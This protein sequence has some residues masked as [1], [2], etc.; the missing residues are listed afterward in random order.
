MMTKV[1]LVAWQHFRQEVLKRSFIMVMLSLPLFLSLSVG[2]GIWGERLSRGDTTLGYVDLAALLQDTA[3]DTG[4]HQV[5]LVPFATA[6]EAQSALTAGRID[7]Y[8]VL[9]ADYAQSGHAELVYEAEPHYSATQAFRQVVRRNLLA[10]QPSLVVDRV[11]SEPKLTVRALDQGREFPSGGPSA[12]QAVPVAVGVIFAFLIVMT[13][14]YL[15]SALAKERE[16]RTMEIIATSISPGQMMLGKVIAGLAMGFVLLVVWLVFFVGAALVARNVLHLA[17]LQ[18][19]QISWREVGMLVVVALPSLVFLGALLTL[20]GTLV[21]GEQDA[22]QIG[23]FFFILVMMPL[24]L[25]VPLMRQPDGPLAVALTMLPSLSVMTV[26]F[27]SMFTVV[28]WWQVLLSAG[29]TLV[30]AGF[31]IRL[32]AKGVRAAMLKYGQRLRLS[33]ILAAS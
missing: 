10:G 11:L 30:C 28:P 25:I 6:D 22:D 17:W 3:A 9:P 33:D 14:G 19:I 31:V 7:A 4:G 5:R 8:F 2:M 18:E 13:A 24:Y 1:R 12:S 15:L 16:N 23:P 27:R 20:V 32:A 21:P 26:A 29:I